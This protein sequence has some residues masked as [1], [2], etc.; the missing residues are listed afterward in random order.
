MSSTEASTTTAVPAIPAPSSRATR[1]SAPAPSAADPESRWRHAARAL[2]AKT[3]AEFAYEDMLA[4]VPQGDGWYVL[5]LETPGG[6]RPVEYRFRAERGAYGSWFV[7]PGSVRRAGH[8]AADPLAFVADAAAT[9]GL[10]G[11][12]AGRLVHEMAATLA[13]DTRILAAAT[14]TAADLADLDHAELDG[15]LTGHPSIVFDKGR[16]GFSAGDTLRYAPEARQPVRLPWIAVRDDLARYEAVP[17]LSARRL[18]TEELSPAARVRFGAELIRHSCNPARYWWLPIH[19]WQW[20]EVIQPLYGTEIAASR[21]VYLGE[22]D[23]SYVPLHSIGTFGN[24]TVPQ[25]HQVK[26]PL[27]VLS[28]TVWHGLSAERT[29]AAPEVTTWL[30]G[31]AEA[32]AFLAECDVA[33]PGD[34]ASVTVGHP[35]FDRIEGVPYRYRELLGAIWR[36]P[37]A[38]AL[39]PG[40]RARSLASLLAFGADGRPLVK[41]LVTRS[42]LAPESWLERL[43]AS[44][45]PPLLRLLY[46]YG[47]AYT[48]PS[49][50][51]IV[52]YDEHEVPARLAVRDCVDGV[53][54]VAADLPELADLPEQ[55]AA[56]LS[57]E[58]ADQVSL[59]LHSGLFAGHLRYL[60]HICEQHLGVPAD[61]FWE[62]VR[63]AVRAYQERFPEH[64]FRYEL[65]D[66]SAN[67]VARVCPNRSR[68]LLDHDRDHPA[69]SRSWYGTVSNPLAPHD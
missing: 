26:I 64:A 63:A 1:R 13:A 14:L 65:F 12:S 32:D 60:A 69:G 66:L 58:E 28:A 56:V 8:P 36:E 22:G 35:V 49:G 21:M 42:G 24:I 6:G 7:D 61:G 4:P 15:R 9:L 40:E 2:L 68:L 16:I 29:A 19:P 23:D 45:L 10:P 51:A 53:S 39:H 20:D 59:R 44:L 30:R 34:V 11:R 52:I 48:S 67:P 37:L 50:S 5:A 46:A 25:R 54:L 55:V 62:R 27:T 31:I 18:Y 41:E 17:G 47:T 57:R 38:A 3:I 43:F 33:V